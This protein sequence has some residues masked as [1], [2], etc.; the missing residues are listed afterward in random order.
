VRHGVDSGRFQQTAHSPSC[1]EPDVDEHI[2]F[3]RTRGSRTT[4]ICNPNDSGGGHP[5]RREIVRFIDFVE[6]ERSH[7]SEPSLLTHSA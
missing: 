7:S 2:D 5:P 6:V 1:F 4:V 3:I